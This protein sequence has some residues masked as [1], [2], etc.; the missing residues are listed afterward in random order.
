M[1][2]FTPK[3]VSFQF[4]STGDTVIYTAAAG[5]TA[6]LKQ[7][8]AVETSGAD[9]TMNVYLRKGAGTSRRITDK[10]YSLPSKE[11]RS[12]A[13]KLNNAI[14]EPGDSIRGDASTNN[15]I[16]GFLSLIEVT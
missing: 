14:L 4:S 7:L 16:D 12:F 5:V 1:P 8:T 10:D 15:V 2:T 6:I 13:D 11:S 9:K 3:S